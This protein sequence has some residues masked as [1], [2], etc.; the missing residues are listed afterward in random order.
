MMYY[1][2][3]CGKI[4]KVDG[5]KFF[6]EGN[7][8]DKISIFD[9]H[10]RIPYVY[11]VKKYFGDTLSRHIIGYVKGESENPFDFLKIGDF[12][13]IND[14]FIYVKNDEIFNEVINQKDNVNQILKKNYNEDYV[15]CWKRV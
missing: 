4:V 8:K 13:K 14:D 15:N 7:A 3:D 2:L 6:Y 12:V 11:E 5:I 9:G 10:P 1:L